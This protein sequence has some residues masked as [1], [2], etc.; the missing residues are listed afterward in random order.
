M[1]VLVIG[2][3]GYVG[4]VVCEQLEAAHI[5]FIIFDNFQTPTMS[6]EACTTRGWRLIRGDVRDSEAVDSAFHSYRPTH[7]IHLAAIHYIPYCNDNPSETIATNVTGVHN[8]VAAVNKYT[9]AA[10]YI[11][12]SSAA[13]YSGTTDFAAEAD[14]LRPDDI[15][16]LTKAQGELVVRGSVEDHRIVR[17]FNVFGRKDPHE[18]LIPKIYRDAIIAQAD[19]V[20]GASNTVRDFVHVEDVADCIMRLLTYRGDCRIFNVGTGSAYSVTD[21]VAVFEKLY[22]K[23]IQ[24]SYQH[25]DHVRNADKPIL[26]ADTRL[27]TKEL[28]WQ[29]KHDITSGIR[30]VHI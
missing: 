16:G 11:F 19:I 4:T 3:A 8:I 9:P 5:P 12:I 18:H 29:P 28:Q 30:T 20:L 27:V 17:L 7:I 22:S 14:D 15:Y 21:I 1:R 2:G 26:R 6:E 24:A 25:A 13:V 23:T 10:R